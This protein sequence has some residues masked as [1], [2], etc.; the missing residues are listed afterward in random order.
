MD[1]KFS[2]LAYAFETVICLCSLSGAWW[3]ASLYGGGDARTVR[4]MMLAPILYAVAEFARVPLAILL[5]A[6]RSIVLR[7]VLCIGL[8]ASAG[9]TV[10]QVSLLG[11]LWAW[12]RLIEV[13]HSRRSRSG[14][15]MRQPG[16]AN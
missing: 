10:K 5:R 9:I 2:I 1:R 12:P 13:V 6:E 14:R 7:L 8:I 15:P 16:T 3:F 11:Q 4:L